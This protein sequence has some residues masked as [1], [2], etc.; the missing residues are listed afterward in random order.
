VFD[1]A[2]SQLLSPASDAF[3]HDGIP[4]VLTFFQPVNPAKPAKVS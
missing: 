2:K 3:R 1:L 4:P